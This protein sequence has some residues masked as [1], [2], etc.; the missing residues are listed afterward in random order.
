MALL[1]DLFA[2]NR[3]WS[4][5]VREQ[6]P[7]YFLELSKQQAPKYLWVGCSDSRVP[8]NQIVDLPPG[9]V[10][11]H[12]NRAHG[13]QLPVGCSLRGARAPRRAHYCL[14]SLRLRRGESRAG[15]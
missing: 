14:W 11:V 4:E 6:D 5:G 8:A 1:D 13:P 2:K 9:E 3:Q 12:R 10:F 7:N 15:W